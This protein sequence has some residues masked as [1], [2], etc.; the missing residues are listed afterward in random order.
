MMREALLKALENKPSTEATTRIDRL[1]DL[2]KSPSHAPSGDS[3]RD[4]RALEVLE[5]IATPE[6]RALLEELSKGAEHTR[7]TDAARA[8]LNRVGK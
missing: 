7:L 1:L 5:S 6:A 2:A 4:L 3:L 8:A